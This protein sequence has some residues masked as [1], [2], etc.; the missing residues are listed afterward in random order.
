MRRFRYF[1]L[2]TDP[3]TYLYSEEIFENKMGKMDAMKLS[4]HT[5]LFWSNV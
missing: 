1:H 5:V 2:R 4:E 3:D